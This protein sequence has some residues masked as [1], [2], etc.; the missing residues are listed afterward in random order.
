MDLLRTLIHLHAL[1]T[2]SEIAH[3][4][5]ALKRTRRV[6]TGCVAMAAMH[7]RNALIGVFTVGAV[8]AVAGLTN[9]IVRADR[10]VA[11]GFGV[12]AVTSNRAFVYVIALLAA[13]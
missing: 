2:F 1:S 7:F 12:A 10:V 5:T 4:A 9:T 13:A 3:A 11:D 8:A 6:D